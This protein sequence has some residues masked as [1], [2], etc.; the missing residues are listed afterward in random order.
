MV[1]NGQGEDELAKGRLKDIVGG[2]GAV[3]HLDHGAGYTTLHASKF[4]EL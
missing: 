2:G 4:A 1:A 3:L